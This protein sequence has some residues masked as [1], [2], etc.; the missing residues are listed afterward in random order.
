M[1]KKNKRFLLIV[2]LSFI[3][4]VIFQRTEVFAQDPAAGDLIWYTFAGGTN[5]DL[6]ADIVLDDQGNIYMVGIS[7]AT[8]GSP[9]RAY[10]GATDVCVAKFNR[11]GNL[12]WNTFLGGSG[13]D[14]G[15]RSDNLYRNSLALDANGNIFITGC[16]KI[17]W[18]T[19]TPIY[20]DGNRTDAFIAKLDQDGNF[21]WNKF[22]GGFGF[23]EAHGICVDDYDNIYVTGNYQE[24]WNTV[25]NAFLLKL[26]NDGN[27]LWET[28]FGT[29][30]ANQGTGVAVTTNGVY[31]TG[32]SGF[33]YTDGTWGGVTPVNAGVGGSDAFAA[34]F[35][36]GGVLQW[37][38]FMG[39]TTGDSW[40]EVGYGIEADDNYI[41]VV[42]TSLG[43]GSPVNPWDEGEDGFVSKFNESNG[44][45]I[46]NTFMGGKMSDLGTD[47]ALDRYGNIYVTG[48]DLR[49]SYE[50][51]GIGAFACAL[52]NS[53]N[54]VWYKFLGL[55][56]PL[57]NG[58]T[59]GWGLFA[60]R[61]GIISL[62]GESTDPWRNELYGAPLNPHDGTAGY[63]DIFVAEIYTDNGMPASNMINNIVRVDQGDEATNIISITDPDNDDLTITSNIGS[64][65][66]NG[67]GTRTWSSATDEISIGT[68]FVNF[69]IN[70]GNGG[71]IENT[72]T[73]QVGRVPTEEEI[74]DRTSD[75]IGWIANEQ[76]ED[77]SWNG[78]Y[79]VIENDEPV[80][81]TGFALTKLCSYAYENEYSPF[82]E[83]FPYYQN[84]VDGFDYLFSQVHL[85]DDGGMFIQA[86][87]NNTYKRDYNTAVAMMAIAA[88]GTPDA[89]V[90][91]SYL[92][93]GEMTHLQL[94][95]EMVSYFQASQYKASESF[96]GWGN[97]TFTGYVAFSLRYAEAY[98]CDIP[99]VIKEDL[100]SWID[101]I[102]NDVSG[103]AGFMNPDDIETL[104]HM[105]MLNTANLLIQMAFV[106]D[107][108]SDT[109]V[110]NALNFI[111]YL[112][113]HPEEDHQ[114]NERNIELLYCLMKAFE[115]FGIETLQVDGETVNWYE[116]FATQL[117]F[118]SIQ[119]EEEGYWIFAWGGDRFLNTCWAPLTLEKD[120]P[121]FSVN[122]PPVALCQEGFTIVADAN[123]EAYITLAEVDNGSYDPDGDPVTIELSSLGP[124]YVGP[125]EVTLVITDNSEASDQCSSIVTVTDENNPVIETLDPEMDLT[126]WPPNHQYETFQV[127]DFVASVSDNCESNISTDDIS[128]VLVSSDEPENA[129]GD[130]DGN[131]FNDIVISDDCKSV[132]LRKERQGTENGRVYTIQLEVFD[133]SG[134]SG[135]A[136][137]QVEVPHDNNGTAI[138]DGPV[139]EVSGSCDD[140]SISV[141]QGNNLSVNV[142]PNPLTTS[143]TFEFK[144]N[145]PQTVRIILYN[146]FGKKVGVID[147][148]QSSGVQKV[149]WT[150]ENLSSGIYFYRLESGQQVSTGKV[151]LF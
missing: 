58:S 68:H 117:L 49:A 116:I 88:A 46:W 34:K 50:G 28:F 38:T 64:F 80:A 131:T 113:A 35:S 67:D 40:L 12:I 121:Q 8:W 118:F 100:S 97:S 82:E 126:I 22:Y 95:N 107:H 133:E 96:G 141:D 18:G 3:T 139:Y 33:Y 24:D 134:N 91:L 75:G 25:V 123:C 106:G 51:G 119:N 16:S 149:V 20:M 136:Y 94:M 110:Q 101:Y 30:N 85:S 77:G 128:I 6:G 125:N 55:P 44:N 41:Y 45:L 56:E 60:Q 43:W 52:D 5:H 89:V 105:Q 142:Y 27:K 99:E 9:K 115:G 102:Q 74:G 111:E 69:I 32:G 59:Y 1:K 10:S 135:A 13:D 143:T 4:S 76:K 86:D 144:L 150:P 63:N 109:R 112:W 137:C 90:D 7:S 122:N 79:P 104:S 72:F 98:G 147:Q 71:I 73:L 70:D 29:T 127:S 93:S 14:K 120:A 62:V 83:S 138:D 103:G 132:Q 66:D 92:G 148:A 61:N 87:V 21:L 2:L 81:S 53:G 48:T 84:V 26:D 78:P 15:D 42:G 39:N 47:L 31:V 23:D 108:L 57:V 140:K 145:H 54:Q 19:G 124:F 17:S 36:T 151:V 65:A 130:G 114:W 146:Q 37:Y 11:H 129:E